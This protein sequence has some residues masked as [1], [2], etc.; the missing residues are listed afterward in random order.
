MA[1]GQQE[2]GNGWL[3]VREFYVVWLLY[4][5]LGRLSHAVSTSWSLVGVSESNLLKIFPV[6]AEA[7]TFPS[8][9][10]IL[11]CHIF[12]SAEVKQGKIGIP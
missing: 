9:G 5:N 2:L 11:L 6:N 7:E 3:T 1:E 12:T 10:C 8:C 4:L